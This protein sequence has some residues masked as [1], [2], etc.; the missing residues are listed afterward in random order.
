[1]TKQQDYVTERAVPPRG[2]RPGLNPAQ[3]LGY[4]LGLFYLVIGIVGLFITGWTASDLTGNTD[5]LIGIRINPLRDLIYLA[6][7]AFLLIMC[8][9][10]LGART[11]GAI[12]LLAYGLMLIWGV[13]IR[14]DL[15]NYDGLRLDWPSNW[16][17]LGT[18]VLGL[19]MMLIPRRRTTR[20]NR[21]APGEGYP[22]GRGPGPGAERRS[23]PDDRP[24]RDDYG[25]PE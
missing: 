17:H 12:I 6:T 2:A 14:E 3:L 4:A 23:G 9:R 20:M 16:M 7:G 10:H 22:A 1:M 5:H 18:A 13:L 24:H 8:V 11:A 19:T 21:L 25:S 15:L